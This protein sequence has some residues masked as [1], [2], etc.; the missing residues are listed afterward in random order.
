MNKFS[1]EVEVIIQE[2]RVNYIDAVV[3]W[4]EK[5]NVEVE[6]AADVIKKDAVMHSKIR[7]DAE[8]LNILKRTAQLPV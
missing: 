6:Y 2:K 5:N 1:V 8:S 7:A 3:M 4:C